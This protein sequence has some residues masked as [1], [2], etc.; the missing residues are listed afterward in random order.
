M[1]FEP[2]QSGLWIGSTLQAVGHVAATGEIIGS[3]GGDFAIAVK[4]G[5]VFC[6]LPLIIWLGFFSK[7][8]Q[9]DMH[10]NKSWFQKIKD[11]W[12]L[13]GFIFFM[14]CSS[15]PAFSFIENLS[16]I[17]LVIAMVGIGL[18]IDLKIIKDALEENN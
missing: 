4:M 9:G 11:L 1:I 16:S 17:P 15:L 14:C 18:S 12:Y 3:S 7:E 6:L 8:M 10:Q 2:I 13:W 5:R